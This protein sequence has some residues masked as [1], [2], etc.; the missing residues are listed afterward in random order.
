MIR[1]TLVSRRL[2]IRATPC[3]SVGAAFA[4]AA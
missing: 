2:G 1:F 3:L 4:D